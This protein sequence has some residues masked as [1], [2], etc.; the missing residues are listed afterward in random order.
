MFKENKRVVATDTLIGQGTI[1]EGKLISEANLRIEGEYRGDIECKGDI[2]IGE[3]GIVRSNIEAR[4]ITLAGKL[5]GDI[6]TK[7]RLIITGTGQ[8]SGSV[9]AH[10]LIIQEGGQLSGQCRMEQPAESKP[11][12]GAAESSEAANAKK[13]ELKNSESQ[14]KSRQAG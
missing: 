4:D 14:A 8:L 7:G 1:V 10:A 3:C 9:A 11:R 5:Y 2:I 6:V 13:D 12:S